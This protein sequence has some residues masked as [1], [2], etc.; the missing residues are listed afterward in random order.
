MTASRVSLRRDAGRVVHDAGYKST[1]TSIFA[2]GV[3]VK[4][5]LAAGQRGSELSA[6]ALEDAGAWLQPCRVTIGW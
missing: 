2:V 1:R 5:P 4:H 3:E 6:Q